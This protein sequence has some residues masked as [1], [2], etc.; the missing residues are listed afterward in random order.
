MNSFK[1]VL[2][3]DGGVGKSTF[4][5]RCRTGE[6][7]KK[8]IPTMGVDVG[9]LT[10]DTN[11]GIVIFKV[12]DCAG[13]EKLGGLKEGYYQE[14]QGAIVMFDLTSRVTHTNAAKWIEDIRQVSPD[15][16]VI[17]CGNKCDIQDR[18]VEHNHINDMLPADV[19]Y[20][21]ISAR[22]NVDLNSPWLDLAKQLTGHG[23]LEFVEMPPVTPPTITITSI[24]HGPKKTTNWLPIPGYGSM[25]ITTKYEYYPEHK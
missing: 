24:D 16:P 8:Y 14:A 9:H 21:Q 7:E 12:W 4:L 5:K 6:F 25:K 18:K 17:L 15:I 22:R 2:I 19:N 11:Y 10:F 3:G 13:Q 1:V 20:F 23:D